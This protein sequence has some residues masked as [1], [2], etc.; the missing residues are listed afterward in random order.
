MRTP[1]GLICAAI[2]AVHVALG[3]G[4]TVSLTSPQHGQ[5]V[6]PGASVNW[7]VAFAVSPSSNQG[8]AAIVCDLIQDGANPAFLDI[9]A[10]DGVPAAMSNFATPAGISNPPENQALTGYIGVLRGPPG[11]RD[12]RQIG[13]AQN[14]F[15]VPRPPGSGIGESAYVVAAVGQSAPQ[16]LASGS[17][18]APMTCGTYVFRLSGVSA[19][20]LVQRRDPPLPSRSTPAPVSMNP[21]SITFV[22]RTPGDADGDADVDQD[23]IDIVLFYF[24]SVV[25]PWTNGDLD[26]DGNVDQDDIDSVL[27]YQGTSC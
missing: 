10:A 7:S 17:F 8:L 15:G 24:G 3:Q 27:F 25:T 11:R 16:Q 1:I 2:V 19:N 20:V 14:T 12:L 6:P 26:G 23:D 18:A 9:P 21:A 4:V 22:I 5:V 13:G